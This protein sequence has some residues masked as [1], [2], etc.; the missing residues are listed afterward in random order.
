LNAEP[1]PT[2]AI[3]EP[4]KSAPVECS[5]TPASVTLTPITSAASRAATPCRT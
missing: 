2:P 4:P 5:C 3:T 1:K